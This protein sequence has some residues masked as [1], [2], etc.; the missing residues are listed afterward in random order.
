MR[1]HWQRDDRGALLDVL[2]GPGFEPEHIDALISMKE[3]RE[4]R[5]I[6]ELK[7]LLTDKE[8]DQ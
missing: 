4:E 8:K 5:L 3:R 2:I 7:N 6:E 1:A